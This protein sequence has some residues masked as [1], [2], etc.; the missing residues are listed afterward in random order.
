M[1]ELLRTEL[2]YEAAILPTPVFCLQNENVRLHYRRP[3]P[4]LKDNKTL[5][6]LTCPIR[7]ILIN[8]R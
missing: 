8:K 6:A 3:L 4:P 2:T 5:T 1:A 7:A